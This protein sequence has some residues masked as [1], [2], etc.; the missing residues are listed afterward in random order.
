[1]T[2]MTVKSRGQFN[3]MKLSVSNAI[4]KAFDLEVKAIDDGDSASAD[5]LFEQ[6]MALSSQLSAIRKA[7]IA[8]LNS[9][10]GV[11][12]AEAILVAEARRAKN[13]LTTMMTVN[14]ALQSLAVL[15]G[16][17]TSLA[18]FF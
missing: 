6:R 8:Y 14:S 12:E 9:E 7:E 2:A 3:S 18:A 15:L 4:G 10:K 13:A 17:V 1:M 5:A 11:E 16:L